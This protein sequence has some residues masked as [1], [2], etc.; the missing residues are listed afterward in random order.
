MIKPPSAPLTYLHWCQ[1]RRF[2]GG[3]G[4][5]CP[6]PLTAVLLRMG[7]CAPSGEYICIICK[8]LESF[9]IGN[10]LL[11]DE[12]AMAQQLISDILICFAA[13]VLDRALRYGSRGAPLGRPIALLYK[14]VL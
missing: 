8:I 9:Y 10:S 1:W 3:E 2:R 14:Y 12:L 4:G 5:G 6:P 11:G 13:D 7:P